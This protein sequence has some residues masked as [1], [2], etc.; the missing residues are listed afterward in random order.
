MPQTRKEER[1]KEISN[2]LHFKWYDCNYLHANKYLTI[3]EYVYMYC[4]DSHLP[5]L[6]RE[7]V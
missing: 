3:L 7:A 5:K 2:T 6:A 4:C 1:K